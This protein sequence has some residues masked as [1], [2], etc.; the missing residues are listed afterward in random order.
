MSCGSVCNNITTSSVASGL[1]TALNV[2]SDY[3]SVTSLTVAPRR[4]GASAASRQLGSVSAAYTIV[5][6][7]SSPGVQSSL[8]ATIQNSLQGAGANGVAKAI[9]EAVQTSTG[10]T[11][12]TVTVAAPILTVATT[13]APSVPTKSSG[14]SDRLQ[15]LQH[16]ACIFAA[17]IYI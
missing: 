9:A 11:G 2:S 7:P 4:L 6:P 10:L 5:L 16:F 3:V 1:A 17:L 12:I 15:I 8:V 14:A 13:P